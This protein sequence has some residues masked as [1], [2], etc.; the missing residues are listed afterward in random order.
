MKKFLIFLVSIVVM[1]SF[2]LITYYFLRND[3]VITLGTK[4]IFCNAGE[5][6]SLDELNISIKKKNKKTTYDFNAG[7]EEVTK[8]IE[9]DE[10]SNAYIVSEDACGNIAVTITTSNPKCSEFIVNVHVGNGSVENPYYVFNESFLSK[11]GTTYKLNKSYRL[12]SDITLSEGFA[13]IGASSDKGFV[14]IFNGNGH[15]ITGLTLNK[16]TYK[17]A[18]LFAQIGAEGSVFDLILDKVNIDGSYN[19][20]GALAGIVNGSVAKIGVTNSTI[21][22]EKVNGITGSVVGEFNGENFKLVYA[23]KVN[24]IIGKAKDVSTAAEIGNVTVGGLVGK[25][26]Q[27]DVKLS[28]ANNV[29]I[30]IRD[31]KGNVGGFVGEFIIGTDSIG[32]IHQ[33]YANAVI[34]SDSAGAFV[35]KVSKNATFDAEKDVMLKH[36]V[37]NMAVG[38]SAVAIVFDNSEED[39]KY[40]EGFFNKDKDLYL[41]RCFDTVA[42]MLEENE[43][44]VYFAIDS[45]KNK[46]TYW[47]TSYIWKNSNTEL[48]T[49]RFGTVNDVAAPDSEY[50]NKDLSFDV[51]V[52][53]DPET[54]SDPND[55]NVPSDPNDP[56]APSNPDQPEV[57]SEPNATT[58]FIEIFNGKDV[59][60]KNYILKGNVDLTNT[61][62]TPGALTNVVL[63]GN[64]YTIKVKLSNANNENAGL[65]SILDNTTIT[66]LN[67]EV[68]EMSAQAQNVGALAG[69]VISTN[70]SSVS[71]IDNV[72]VVYTNE[73][74]AEN[75]TYFGGIAAIVDN[76]TFIN[77][78]KVENL[79][80]KNDSKIKNAGGIVA[81]LISGSVENSSATNVTVSATDNA[82]GIVAINDAIIKNVTG[83]VNVNYNSNINNAKV[84]GVAA[85]NRHIIADS[86]IAVKI[87]VVAAGEKIYVGGVTA[88]N[89]GTIEKVNVS[90]DGIELSS[91][92]TAYVGGIAA[93]NANLIDNAYNNMTQTGS[94]IYNNNYYVGG[95]TAINN[96]TIT[97]SVVASNISGNYVAGVTVEMKETADS[98]IDEVLVGVYNKETKETTQNSINGD[99]FIA[100]IVMD[101]RVGTITNIQAAS[102][103]KG[104]ATSTRSSLVAL[105]FPNG[106]TLS[107]ATINSSLNGYGVKY[108][109]SWT[110]FESYTNKA[111]FGFGATATGSGRFNIYSGTSAG[112]MTSVVINKSQTGVANAKAS[113]GYV[114]LMLGFIN[115]GDDYNG[116]NFVK[117]VNGFSDISQF[118][119][120]FS[121]TCAQTGK[122]SSTA[123][124]TLTFNTNSVWQS[125]NGI[126]LSFLDNLAY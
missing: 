9:Y 36:F 12:M 65:F 5:V 78:S 102:A 108:R 38:K 118:Q 31:A 116:V 69:K 103:I 96:G 63:D 124:K 8:F 55:P 83:S 107:N 20:A 60:D 79:T 58:S 98:K 72:K 74:T 70:D 28:Y 106:A 104:E 111:Q 59:A 49:L 125:N 35:G 64:G 62:W 97:K 34:N 15:T 32:S 68:V 54:P 121:F 41:I 90:G 44:F 75:I 126:S 76:G 112:K 122:Y 25:I 48:P 23:D 114:N 19:T 61:D 21:T 4:E 115:I 6:I 13:P 88:Q 24:L 92:T 33:S 57:P 46:V 87:N 2:G 91:S 1:V 100:G 22:N 26:N 93:N 47:D 29:T 43:N 110:D 73:F 80:I 101:F 71:K 30:N 56:N 42:K 95:L 45:S 105:I 51:I 16:D 7:G 10:K 50:F 39:L 81:H 52:P 77:N 40:F 113:M 14:G 27:T 94:Y 53:E 18:G 120:S 11:I 99:K 37:G 85:L 82:G 3:E 117:T 119:G 17:N 109:E 123:T 89:N 67:I 66:N 86:N 84:G